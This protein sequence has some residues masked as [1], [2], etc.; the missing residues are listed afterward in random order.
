MNIS[1][2]KSVVVDL[3]TY[4]FIKG[5]AFEDERTINKTLKQYFFKGVESEAEECN[6][7]SELKEGGTPRMHR[8]LGDLRWYRENASTKLDKK[9]I[10]DKEEFKALDLIIAALADSIE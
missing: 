7:D 10:V 5:L 2:Y 6:L 9:W 3:E 1:K 8:L 4:D